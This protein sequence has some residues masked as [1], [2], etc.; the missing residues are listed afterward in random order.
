VLLI[1]QTL[2]WI[3]DHGLSFK[4]NSSIT[5][6]NKAHSFVWLCLLWSF[7][8]CRFCTTGLPSDI[9]VEV[10]EMSFHLHKVQFVK[11]LSSRNT[12]GYYCIYLD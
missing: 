2:V 3:W 7:A 9:V 8:N 5:E 10:G 1:E 4:A 11:T 6:L 12:V